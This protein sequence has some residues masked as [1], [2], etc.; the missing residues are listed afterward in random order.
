MKSILDNFFVYLGLNVNVEELK[1]FFSKNTNQSVKD[2]ILN[3]LGIQA[4]MNIRA[5]FDFPL[6]SNSRDT[7]YDHIM[8]MPFSVI[9][10]GV[11]I[12]NLGEKIVLS[13]SKK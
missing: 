1:I 10:E 12:E 3:M 5:Y 11:V 8:I 7:S 6:Q 13:L 4:T 9:D 2:H